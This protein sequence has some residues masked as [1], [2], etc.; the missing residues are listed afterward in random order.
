[1][2]K[3][4]HRQDVEDAQ[5]EPSL[6][7][8]EAAAKW[9]GFALGWVEALPEY[10]G[11]CGADGRV[12]LAMLDCGRAHAEFYFGRRSSV[13]QLGAGAIGLFAADLQPSLSRWRCDGVRR[14]L[15]QF[16]H[17]SLDDDVLSEQL[18][19]MPLRSEL[20]FHDDGLAAVL[21]GMAHEVAG[22]CPSGPLYAESLSLGV[23]MQ[24]QRRAAGRYAVQRERGKLS[25]AQVKSVKDMVRI[26]LA[27]DLS[28]DD[29]ALA[30]GFSRTQF[31][32]LFKNTFA[33]TP[34][35]YILQARLEHARNLVLGSALPLTA[36]AE[37]SGF[38]SQSHMT[39]AMVRSFR[40]TPGQLR[41]E[42]AH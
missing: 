3:L 4:S 15:L 6:F 5:Q 14:I 24:L 21:R 1:M 17:T 22:G 41:R 32:R 40:V 12:M 26:Q 8:E 2:A 36:I 20:E 10:A 35:Q 13:H 42:Q 19:R 11:L 29:L 31:V 9:S 18:F 37:D 23:A 7:S 25:G 39:T 28:I 33:C 30:T 27:Q 16:D 34:Y 38:S